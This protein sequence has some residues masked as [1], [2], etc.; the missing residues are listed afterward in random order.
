M[1]AG[2]R[3]RTRPRKSLRGPCARSPRSRLDEATSP[4]Y[5]AAISGAS[6]IDKL[7]ARDQ[8][9]RRAAVRRREGKRDAL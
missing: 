1:T 3:N 2:N 9:H 7:S 8:G 6:G 4:V 5:V